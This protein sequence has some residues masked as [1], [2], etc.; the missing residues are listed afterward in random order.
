MRKLFIV[1][2]AITMTLLAGY[3]GYRSYK[4]WKQKHLLAM[5]RDFMSHSD[6]RDALLALRQAIASNPF[7][8]EASRLAAE[9]CQ[10]GGSPETLRWRARVVQLDP[11]STRD[12]LALAEAA[13]SQRDFAVATNALAGIN[14]EGKKTA[15]Y[16]NI[17]GALAASLSHF[18]EAKADFLEATRLDPGNADL[19]LNLAVTEIHD[20]N[21][22]DLSPARAILQ[23]LSVNSTNSTLRCQALRE[24]TVDAMRHKNSQSALGFSKQL[25]Q[26]TNALFSDHVLRLEILHEINDPQ[27]ASDLQDLEHRSTTNLANISELTAWQ[28]AHGLAAQGVKWLES[29]PAQTRTNQAVAQL[30]AESYTMLGNWPT[31]QKTLEHQQWGGADFARHAFLARAFR[32]QDLP[33]AAQSE[34][35]QAVAEASGHETAQMMLLTLAAKW[36]WQGESEELLW[37]AVK[38]HPTQPWAPEALTRIFFQD[39]RTRSLMDLFNQQAKALPSDL[40]LKNNLAMTALLLNDKDLKPH[41]LAQ[42]VYEKSPTNS[43]FA[44]TYAFSLFLQKKN[45]E[46]LS[47]MER[48]NPKDLEKP[49]IAGY[50]GL[51]LQANGELAKARKYFELAAKAPHLPEEQKLFNTARARG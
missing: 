29:L 24:L 49:S 3:A 21:A 34:W 41:E 46:A 47:I 28:Q 15:G 6:T 35:N 10:A 17:S 4:V 40:A 30:M 36:R 12:R 22:A 45:A 23:A 39:G 1:L 42:E 5:A 19:Q 43:S 37:T 11:N 50:Y 20:T 26:Q 9:V 32:G 14:A 38:E 18:A 13:I 44:S 25:L 2:I 8:V 33:D 27:F 31:L 48:L 16:Y 7:N 51:I